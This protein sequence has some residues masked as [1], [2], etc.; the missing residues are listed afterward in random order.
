MILGLVSHGRRRGQF[1]M[2][3]LVFVVLIIV[4][5]IMLYL[6]FSSR[7]PTA[8]VARSIVLEENARSYLLVLSQTDVPACGNGVDITSLSRACAQRERIGQCVD[9]CE[10]LEEAM[11]AIVDQTLDAQGQACRLYLGVGTGAI[12]A[13]S[14]DDDCIPESINVAAAPDIPIPVNGGTA[15]LTLA[16]CRS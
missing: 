8:R 14:C 15:R 13:A 6:V 9:A 10:D 11:R 4:V 12:A 16:L 1:E 3:G 7:D 5:G 2:V